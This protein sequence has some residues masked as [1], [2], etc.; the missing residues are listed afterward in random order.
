[1]NIYKQKSTWSKKLSDFLRVCSGCLHFVQFATS[2]CHSFVV[3][4][5]VSIEAS[6][7]LAT[8]VLFVA[9]CTKVPKTIK[10]GFSRM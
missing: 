9:G 7:G 4:G 5:T 2:L 6:H 10:R 1:M 8:L 3:R